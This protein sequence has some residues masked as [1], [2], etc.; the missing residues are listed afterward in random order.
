[1][2][3]FKVFSHLEDFPHVSEYAHASYFLFINLDDG[4]RQGSRYIF[5][6]FGCNGHAGRIQF[7]H[8]SVL[9]ATHFHHVFS[10]HIYVVKAGQVPSLHDFPGI[11]SGQPFHAF[12]KNENIT[13]GIH[14][15]NAINSALDHVFKKCIGF[16]NLTFKFYPG[17]D[18]PGCLHYLNKLTLFIVNGGNGDY[19][20]AVFSFFILEFF[21]RGENLL[22]F[23]FF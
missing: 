2:G 3:F 11:V 23:C 13:F 8:R 4:G 22:L 19:I 12:I 16:L 20:K 1:M 14:N 9:I 7:A 6:V 17:S 15:N 18:I 10:G 5:T 21:D